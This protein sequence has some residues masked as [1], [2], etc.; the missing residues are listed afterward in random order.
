MT[1][2]NL[3]WLIGFLCLLCAIPAL[4]D[5]VVIKQEQRKTGA[6]EAEHKSTIY[7]GATKIRIETTGSS[8]NSVMI[9]DG[10][11]KVLWIVDTRKK[12]YYEM[13]EEDVAKISATMKKMQEQMAGLPAAQR[14]MMEKMMKG[15]MSQARTVETRKVRS[16][17]QEGEYTC[18]VYEVS[19][20][21][22]RTSEVWTAPA[23]QVQL[24]PEDFSVFQAMG[25]MMEPLSQSMPG[26]AASP[27]TTGGEQMDG[28]PVRTVTY[29]GDKPVSEN[30][31]VGVERRDLE[32]ALFTVPDGYKKKKMGR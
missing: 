7:L 19:V 2:K 4:A 32:D 13:T 18:T 3:F 6:E 25:K 27:L 29:S 10:E 31:V 30:K 1:R 9:F 22:E 26:G 11:R 16:G 14:A 24:Q 28:F 23:G 12:T 5:G 8:A 21:G 17:V 20:N 15:K